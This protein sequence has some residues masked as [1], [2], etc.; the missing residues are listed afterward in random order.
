MSAPH[1]VVVGAGLAGLSSA[2]ACLD[3]GARVTLIERRRHL[4]GLTWS[5]EHDGRWIDNGQHVFLRCCTA[6]QNFLRRI[7]SDGDVELQDRMD[8]TVL[9]PRRG[10][11]RPR[12]AR[13]RRF[14]L[15]A[16]LHL[17][18]AL[19]GFRLLPLRDRLRLGLA[20]VP[21]RHLDL[22]D[23]ALDEQTFGAWLAGHGQSP[24]AIAHL[25]DLITVPTVNL[26][27]AEASL[28]MG[29]KVFQ[30]GLL[31]D[32]AAADIGWSRLPL[33]R[34]HGERA[35]AALARAGAT[36][37]TGERVRRIDP[38]DAEPCSSEVLQAPSGT[39]P[40]GGFAVR[41]E[42]RTIDADAVVVAVPHE[43]AAALL[44]PGSFA[45][46]SRIAELG[47]S[48]IVDVHLHYDRPITD[49]PIAAAVGT[50]AQWIFDRT[51]S[52]GMARA[53]SQYLAVSIS[54]A[55]GEVVR[56]PER[57]AADVAAD[58]ARVLPAAADAKLTDTLVTKERNATWRAA[59]GTAALRPGPSSAYPGL[60]IAGAWTAT[61]WPAT[62]E[63]AVRSGVAAARACLVGAHHSRP[64]PKE[65]A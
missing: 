50:R 14:D 24:M 16:P 20:A 3:A 12:V 4:G 55:D 25:W 38:V 7:G 17:G 51:A 18:P 5:F 32:P 57:V 61:G 48:P 49:L 6:Y 56:H 33:G 43:E 54:A 42:E 35:G 45:Q 53:G 21:L 10:P 29:A 64:L 46:Q 27:A 31:T 11:R 37:V 44:P 2:L 28:A 1:V 47:S 58:I 30:T 60:A 8:I 9:R 22:D 62:M 41:T 59:P 34:L 39:G 19:L 65:V 52:S 63:G 15:P 36:L 40:C 13:L 23:P 26:P